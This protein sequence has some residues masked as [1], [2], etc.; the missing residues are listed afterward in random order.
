[1]TYNIRVGLGFDYKLDAHDPLKGLRRVAD[2]IRAHQ[3]DIVALQEV[4]RFMPRTG[5]VDQ[6]A[7]LAERLD[8]QFAYSPS[9][10]GE[11]T[12]AGG[13]AR[14]GNGLLTR[15]PIVWSES[16]RLFHRGWLLPA[17]ESW[18]NEPRSALEVRVEI[19]GQALTAYSV[20]LSTTTDQQAIQVEQLAKVLRQ[21][22]G[23][24]VIMGDFN[25][26]LD[27]AHMAPLT[28][29]WRSVLDA[30][31]APSERR[32]TFPSGEKSRIA[33]DHILVSQGVR[34]IR[35]EVIVDKEGI[36]D[37]NPVLAE[38]ELAG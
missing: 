3:P 5:K 26:G 29:E 15:F 38:L 13:R 18:V 31:A 20:H 12:H 6:I 21:V 23:H 22:D 19:E 17:E 8:M 16:H 4:D 28:V 36:S 14:Y 10:L 37:H 34:V 7:W 35:A 30:V 24:Q 9:Y 32:L 11:I 1:M 33:I 2:F 25:C 27:A